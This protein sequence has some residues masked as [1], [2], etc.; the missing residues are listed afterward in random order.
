MA[1]QPLLLVG[2]VV[3]CLGLLLHIIGM[4]T[5]EWSVG[6]AIVT[7]NT[8]GMPPTT[9][10]TGT[11]T[12]TKSST[13]SPKSKCSKGDADLVMVF[14]FKDKTSQKVVNSARQ[15]AEEAVT[16]ITTICSNA[17]IHVG[18][19]KEDGT[20][21][22]LKKNTD[23]VLDALKDGIGE[24]ANSRNIS[25]L[26]TTV[27]D[28]IFQENKGDRLSVENFV[29][30]FTNDGDDESIPDAKDLLPDTTTIYVVTLDTETKGKFN[31]IAS[32]P[33]D[34]TIFS[35]TD[36]KDL[37][38]L[39]DAIVEDILDHIEETARQVTNTTEE[40]H[41]YGPWKECVPECEQVETGRAGDYDAVR[42][43]T[44]VGVLCGITSVVV[45]VIM[46]FAQKDNTWVPML[47]GG[48]GI[49]AFVLILLGCIIWG[50]SVHDDLNDSF[51]I[52]YSFALSLVGGMLFGAGGV[53]AFC[54]GR[55]DVQ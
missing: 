1:S 26:L 27:N 20:S 7:V 6:D 43:M 53:L 22:N 38:T 50:A 36:F 39:V 42:F 8:T 28:T 21:L 41:E 5:P 29:I 3:L 16:S 9:Q 44:M 40:A 11:T 30:I 24:T 25:I 23:A 45:S 49:G 17:T 54:G 32:E 2:V 55:D 13:Q 35:L 10:G 12:K 33:T 34:E 47:A 48:T 52:G 37:P 15:A 18:L 51:D 19:V 14:D 31:D 46:V 4:A